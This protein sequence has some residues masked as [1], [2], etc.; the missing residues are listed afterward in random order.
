MPDSIRNGLVVKKPA[1]KWDCPAALVPTVP[2]ARPA[3]LLRGTVPRLPLSRYGPIGAGT[4]KT[5][6]RMA[7]SFS[8]LQPRDGLIPR[9]FFSFVYAA[10]Y[11]EKFARK[12][13]HECP[14]SCTRLH[15]HACPHPNS[16]LYLDLSSRLFAELNREKFEKSLQQLFLK[17]FALS[18]GSLFVWKNRQLRDLSCLV[19]YRPTLP[20]RQSVGRPL[21]GRIVDAAHGHTIYCGNGQGT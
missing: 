19:P 13:W 2:R 3:Q 17:L 20:P 6:V 18:F 5:S 15:E 10:K 12:Y 1:R 14:E 9:S 11:P 16:D 8:Q 4:L 21:P 7:C